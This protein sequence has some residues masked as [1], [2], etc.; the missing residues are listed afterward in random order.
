MHEDISS[1]LVTSPMRRV[2]EYD[3]VCYMS[4][5]LVSHVVQSHSLSVN[6]RLLHI[7][8]HIPADAPA[9]F[10]TD[11]GMFRSYAISAS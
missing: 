8:L 9:Q 6:A 5:L 2:I 1:Y 4:I 3:Q 7:A 11:I 10:Q